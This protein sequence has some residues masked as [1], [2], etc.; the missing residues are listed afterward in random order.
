VA[1]KAQQDKAGRPQQNRLSLQNK[2]GIVRSA[3]FLS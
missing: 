3:Q 1:T 2:D